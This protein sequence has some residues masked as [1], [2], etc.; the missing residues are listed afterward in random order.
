MLTWGA[1]AAITAA[2]LYT[3]V[4]YL[5]TLFAQALYVVVAYRRAF[6][7]SILPF[8]AAAGLAVALFSPWLAILAAHA[9]TVTNNAYLGAPLPA[10]ALALK[11]FFNAGVVFFDLD[12]V[13]HPAAVVVLPILGLALVGIVALVRQWPA[14]GWYVV[15]LGGVTAI[16]FIVPDVLTHESRSTAARYLIP[17]WIAL[18]VA[19]A[20]ALCMLLRSVQRVRRSAGVAAFARVA[21][22]RDRFG[23]GGASGTRP[24]GATAASRRSGRS[25]VSYE[26]PNAP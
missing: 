8:A 11:W 25:R 22:L 12:Y 1:F 6:R 23:G 15:A 21:R 17:T 18:E 26:P 14:A 20:Y 3:D 2:A 10:T 24:G 19:V 7:R 13:W 4:I 5:Y 16:A 9:R